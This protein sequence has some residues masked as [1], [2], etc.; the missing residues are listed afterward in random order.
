MAARRKASAPPSSRDTDLASHL[1]RLRTDASLEALDQRRTLLHQGQLLQ[2]ERQL[3][4]LNEAA[5]QR[6][7]LLQ[8]LSD[9]TEKL[10]QLCRQV[11][12]RCDTEKQLFRRFCDFSFAADLNFHLM[13]SLLG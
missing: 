3:L 12:S 5:A 8:D 6:R 7:N 9:Q 2:L 4:V 11:R 10:A 1:E 13:S